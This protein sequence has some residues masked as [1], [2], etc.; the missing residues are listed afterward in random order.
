MLVQVDVDDHQDTLKDLTKVAIINNLTI[1]CAWSSQEASRYLEIYKSFE[2]KGPD[3]IK[4]RKDND[5]MSRM[6]SLL[7]EVRGINKT[8]VITLTSHI[9]VRSLLHPH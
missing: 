8:D 4:E 5:Y 2:R 3:L 7:T 1:V 6:N 9:G